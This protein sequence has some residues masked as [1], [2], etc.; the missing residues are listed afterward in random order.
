MARPPK[1]YVCQDGE[2]AP[3]STTISGMLNKPALVGW[4]G[5]EMHK[6]GIKHGIACWKAGKEKEPIPALDKWTTIL[7]GQRDLAAEAGTGG[8]EM[9]QAWLRS[10]D[11]EAAVSEISEEAKQGARRA[12]DSFRRWWDRSRY[13]LVDME[14]PLVSEK[15]RYGGTYDLLL[16]SPDGHYE[17]GDLKTGG[18]YP[19]HLLQVASYGHLLK[20]CRDIEVS[21]Y[22]ILRITRKKNPDFHHSSYDELGDA[23]QAFICC[24]QLYDLM[25]KVEERTK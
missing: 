19:E 9:S 21:A 4:A 17:L 5:K 10:E 15:Y 18:T 11:P 24:R 13:E 2:P 20:E 23:W 12:F 1:G 7:Y 6:A 25:K 3:G 8:H 16:K 14:V 22:S